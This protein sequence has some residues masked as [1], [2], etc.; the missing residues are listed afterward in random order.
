MSYT[1]EPAQIMPHLTVKDGTT[2][3]DML[4]MMVLLIIILSCYW[5]LLYFWYRN[6]ISVWKD[7]VGLWSLCKLLHNCE[8][9][10]QT[11]ILTAQ[12]KRECT[13]LL[14]NQRVANTTSAICCCIV[15]IAKN[16]LI[17]GLKLSFNT[18]YSQIFKLNVWYHLW[19]NF[20][21]KDTESFSDSWFTVCIYNLFVC[22]RCKSTQMP[23]HWH[24][25]I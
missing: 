7:K 10:L 11:S 22:D 1:S 2:A 21:L 3:A 19:A 13:R 18:K 9:Y 6:Y 5:C 23:R 14:N 24:V 4:F 17:V 12:T 20:L 8:E 25:Y 15:L 16:H